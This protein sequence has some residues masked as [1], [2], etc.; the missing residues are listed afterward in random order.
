MTESTEDI[1][2]GMEPSSENGN[3]HRQF[4]RVFGQS[5]ALSSLEG[6]AKK[7]DTSQQRWRH[8]TD[9]GGWA[10]KRWAAR[11]VLHGGGLEAVRNRAA[12]H[13]AGVSSGGAAVASNYNTAS[14]ETAFTTSAGAHHLSWSAKA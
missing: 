4:D 11:T 1:R 14:E 7:A 8:R 6:S 13:C 5:A 12:D 9:W 3:G 10:G 2:P